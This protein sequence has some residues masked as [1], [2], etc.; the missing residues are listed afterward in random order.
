MKKRIWELDALRGVCIL[1]VIAVHLI[2]DLVELY[3]VVSW[4]Y[5]PLFIWVRD[6]GGVLFVLLSGICATLG[7]HSV[8]R[9]A[10]VFGCG[11]LITAVTVGMYALELADRS[12]LICFGVLHCL[13]ICMILWHFFRKLSTRILATAG[14][15]MILAGFAA[16]RVR[17]NVPFLFFLGLTTPAFQSADY[18]PLLPHLGFFLLGAVIGRT[19]YREKK[20]LLPRF[21]A[22]NPIVRFFRF[23]GRHSLIIYLAHQP[24]I[25]LVLQIALI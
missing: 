14:I 9:G 16:A 23:C 10:L 25:A 12:V 2:F 15:A 8:R 20:T 22:E 1:F 21:P 24:I 19:L 18:F 6:W 5:P 17:V 13:G 4:E 11:M 7:T 3:G